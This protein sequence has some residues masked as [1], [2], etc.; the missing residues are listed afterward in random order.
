[1]ARAPKG[2]EV[3]ELEPEEIYL[4]LQQKS[5]IEEIEIISEVVEISKKLEGTLEAVLL[6]GDG[7]ILGRVPVSELVEKLKGQ[8]E[9]TMVVFDGIVT[10]RLIDAA[11]E[12]G[13]KTL[14][15]ERL[16]RG[17]KIPQNLNVKIFG[18]L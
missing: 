10:A 15:G 5:S 7:T 17:I 18:E 9:A 16:G 12:V 11:L 8:K 14:V 1:M 3:E 2:K 6:H 4:A 13:V